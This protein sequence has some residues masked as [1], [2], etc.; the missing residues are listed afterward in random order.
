[1]EDK[2]QAKKKELTEDEVKEVS[3]GRLIHEED[4]LGEVTEDDNTKDC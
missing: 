3:G 2:E 1:M 4:K